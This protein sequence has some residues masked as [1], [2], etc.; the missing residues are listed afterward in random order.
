MKNSVPQQNAPTL[1]E[2]KELAPS[3]MKPWA[4][5]FKK[6]SVTALN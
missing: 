5:V 4:Y 3:S 1:A 6:V 2:K